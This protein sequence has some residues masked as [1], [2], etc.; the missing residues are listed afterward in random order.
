MLL[1]SSASDVR[2]EATTLSAIAKLAIPFHGNVTEFTR[3]AR[4]TPKQFAIQ[5][6][7]QPI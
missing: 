4:F 3:R 2:F 1:P 7:Y 5:D 6:E